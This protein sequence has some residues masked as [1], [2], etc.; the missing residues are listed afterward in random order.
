[1]RQLADGHWV[2]AFSAADKAAAAVAL[3][4]AK[5]DQLQNLYRDVLAPLCGTAVP[6]TPQRAQ[7]QQQ[8]DDAVDVAIQQQ[9]QQQQQRPP[10]DAHHPLQLLDQLAL[11][12]DASQ[13]QQQVQRRVAAAMSAPVGASL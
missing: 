10:T 13:E 6:S 4:G 2:L 5:S 11:D 1:M 12:E 9:Q 7:E 8:Q 3:V